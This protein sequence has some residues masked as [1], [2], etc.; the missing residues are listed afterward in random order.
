MPCQGAIGLHRQVFLRAWPELPRWLYAVVV[1]YSL[2]LWFGYQ[3]WVLLIRAY[4]RHAAE[5]AAQY[6]ISRVRQLGHL[7]VAVGRGLPPH[8]YYAMQ[9]HRFAANRWWD[10]VF[11]HQLPHWHGVMQGKPASSR[12]RRL[13]A[14][15]GFFAACLLEQ[16]LDG[17]PELFSLRAGEAPVWDRLLQRQ[18]LFFKPVSASRAEGCFVLRFDSPT[19]LY[20]LQDVNGLVTG[21]PLV[22]ERI[23]DYLRQRDYL[24]QPLLCNASALETQLLRATGMGSERISTLRVI[25]SSGEQG[26]ELRLANLERS[27][28]DYRRWKM[29]PVAL[30]TGQAE[31]EGLVVNIPDWSAIVKLVRAAHALCA[32]QLTVGWD[33]VVTD[34]GPR[35]LEGNANWGVQAHQIPPAAPLLC[36]PMRRVYMKKGRSHAL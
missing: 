25:T 10:F 24:V 12:S 16:G 3:G 35:L 34:E 30:D 1:L 14:D 36:G 7:L 5:V 27:G 32:D 17:V 15:K 8:L 11:D 28:A 33:V 18:D 29:Y 23:E 20:S 13:L 21:E 9:L 6:G 2:V 4:R 31:V 26:I 19:A 22:R